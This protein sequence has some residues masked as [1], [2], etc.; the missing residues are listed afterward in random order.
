MKKVV[1][2]IAPKDFRDE[3]LF[4]TKKVLDGSVDVK[5]AST[6]LGTVTGVKGGTVK[7][8]LPIAKVNVNDFD[9]VV[10]VGGPGASAYFDSRTVLQIARNA[11]DNEKVLAAIC[12][13]PTILANAGVLNG[14]RATCYPSEAS[15]LRARGAYYTGNDVEVTGKIVTANGPN[16][17]RDF[18]RVILELLQKI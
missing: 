14:K 18:G 15:S 4:E 8:D 12:I 2:I 9:A 11:Y 7:P 3:E 13:A 6:T 5:I 10:F 16:A 1:M 17:A